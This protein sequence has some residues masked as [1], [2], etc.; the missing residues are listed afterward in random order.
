MRKPDVL[1][2]VLVV[3]GVPGVTEEVLQIRLV[4]LVFVKEV[5]PGLEEVLGSVGGF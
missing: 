4:V 2:M 5:C 1:K 3:W